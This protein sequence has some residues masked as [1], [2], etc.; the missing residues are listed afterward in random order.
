MSQPLVPSPVR[1]TPAAGPELRD[2]QILL[3][4]MADGA[5]VDIEAYINCQYGYDVRCEVVG[6]SGTIS[7]ENPAV[8]PISLAG[9]RSNPVPADWLIRFGDAYRNELQEWIASLIKG[10]LEGPSA[11]DGYA[12][13][14]VAESAVASLKSWARTPV[15]LVDKP[16]FYESPSN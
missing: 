16:S 11:W 1:S 9:N 10:E 2:P 6:T 4:E 15:S 12:A 8:T 3:L 5:V 13:I 14:S 7:V